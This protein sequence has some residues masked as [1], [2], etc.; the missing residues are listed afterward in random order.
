M[1]AKVKKINIYLPPE[2]EASARM[3]ALTAGQSL[4]AWFRGRVTK[5]LKA[6]DALSQAAIK[7]TALENDN[8][9]NGD[10]EFNAE[11]FEQ[12]LTEAQSGRQD[13]PR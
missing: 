4:S 7:L 9:I 10:S 2:L 3:Q 1:T 11:I 5:H 12:E 8:N 13:F 6:D